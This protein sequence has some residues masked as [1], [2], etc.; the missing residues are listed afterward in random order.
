MKRRGRHGGLKTVLGGWDRRWFELLQGKQGAEPSLNYWE[1]QA[2]AA[3]TGAEARGVVALNGSAMLLASVSLAYKDHPYVLS[4]TH[5]PAA[6][7]LATSRLR[8][9]HSL[10]V[11][12]PR[13]AA[14][15]VPG[16]ARYQAEYDR[17]GRW[18]EGRARPL[19]YGAAACHPLLPPRCL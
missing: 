13:P 10:S 17:A 12:A 6:R 1:D 2:A 18:L 8:A 19:G 15:Q 16:R 11:A 7:A 4:L 14:A 5:A 9:G 3:A